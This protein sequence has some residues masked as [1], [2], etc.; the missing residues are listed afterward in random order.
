MASHHGSVKETFTL[1]GTKSED[2]KLRFSLGFCWD[3][4]SFPAK[5]REC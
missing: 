4:A 2:L 5:A 3:R 1:T